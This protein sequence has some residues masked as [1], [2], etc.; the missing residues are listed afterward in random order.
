MAVHPQL[1]R[2]H[3]TQV[4]AFYMAEKKGLRAWLWAQRSASRTAFLL[5][6]SVRILSSVLA[7][8]WIRLLVGAMGKPLNSVFLAFQNVFS[9]GGLGDLGMGG[10]VSL[11]AGQLIGEDKIQELRKFLALAR[12]VFLGLALTCAFAVLIF[13]NWL[14][15]WLGFQ[16]ADGE[17]SASQ[18]FV[19]GSVLMASVLLSS[20]VNNL[21]YACANVMWP[22]VPNLILLQLCQLSHWLLAR[23]GEPLWIQYLPYVVSSLIGLWLSWYYIHKSHPALAELLPVTFDWGMA[24]ALFESCFWVYLVSLGNTIYRA[25]DAMVINAGFPLGTLSGYT[26][27]YKFCE[28]VIFIVL[29]ASYVMLP[30]ITQWMASPNPADQ[31][32]VRVEMR[33]LNQ[34]QTLLGCG[35]ALAYLGGNDLFMRIWWLHKPDPISPAAL[36]VQLA[37][38]LNLAVTTSGDAGIQLALRSGQRGLR[39][40]GTVMAL[41]GLLNLGLSLLAMKLHYL[42]GVAA[43]T[44]VAQSALSLVSSYYICRHLRL[45]WLPWVLKSWMFPLVGICC[46]GWLRS[47]WPPDSVVH[48]CLL[49]ASY[50]AMLVVIGWALGINTAFIKDELA[51][52]KKFTRR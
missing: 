31:E 15:G 45:A 26:Y 17:G 37:F 52:L 16:H 11:R 10:A 38:A 24:V 51:I 43:A 5:Q 36:S 2:C 27:N 39:V 47:F 33:K 20:Y 7:L 49:A 1:G 46:A 12:S 29:T 22:I 48:F 44:V 34:F 3:A 40:S 4:A 41:T 21:N 50:A 28:I 23:H 35:A 32:R 8:M 9:F 14:P 18:V 42:W 13:S 19:L 25:T 6:V 30:K